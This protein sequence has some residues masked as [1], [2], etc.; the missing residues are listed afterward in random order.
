MKLRLNA[1]AVVLNN[2]N[3]ILAIK[4][5]K[6]P[7]CGRLCIPGG[8]IE[9]GE[10]GNETIVR[11]IKEETG[12]ELKDKPTSFGYCELINK[13]LDSYRIVLLFYCNGEGKPA[14]TEEG[15]AMWKKIDEVER[16]GIPFAKEAIRIGKAG[17]NYFRIVE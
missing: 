3:E 5:K 9:P 14:E 15:I 16:D 13:K 2:K 17:E 1:N 4:L 8:G 10:L 7:F 11:E 6:G 12:I